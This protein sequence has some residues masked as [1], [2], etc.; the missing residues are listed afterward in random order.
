MIR[1]IAGILLL[2]VA[3]YCATAQSL[4]V[5]TY[6]IRYDNPQ[7]PVHSWEKRK[8]KVLQIINDHRPD[9]LGVQEALSHQVKDLVGS[10]KNLAFV[11]VGRD[12]GRKAGEFSAIIFRT[13]RFD[14]Q[15]HGDFWLSEKPDE[16]GSIGWDAAHPRI[17]TWAL[18]IDKQ[19]ARKILLVNTHLDHI[20]QEA[21]KRSVELIKSR[22]AELGYDVP[23][24]ITGDFNFTRDEGAVSK[25]Y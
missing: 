4:R 15:E 8:S 23:V 16:P 7:D 2:L 12:D 6:N 14:L 10:E 5:M 3:S 9:V 20:G 25:N 11:G 17:A 24:I 18:V 1:G 21:R 13:D 22:I 19:E